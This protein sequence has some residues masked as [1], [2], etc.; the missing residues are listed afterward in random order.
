[1]WANVTMSHH[2]AQPKAQP[3]AS[4]RL[5]PPDLM[6]TVAKLA[7]SSGEGLSPTPVTPFNLTRLQDV[8]DVK[9]G[10]DTLLTKNAELGNLLQ[11]SLSRSYLFSIQSQRIGKQIRGLIWSLFYLKPF[12]SLGDAN[13]TYEVSL[14]MTLR[15][16]LQHCTDWMSQVDINA[17]TPCKPGGWFGTFSIFPYKRDNHPNWLSYF[18]EGLKPPTRRIC[19]VFHIW[20]ECDGLLRWNE[21]SVHLERSWKC[22]PWDIK[23]THFLYSIFTDLLYMNVFVSLI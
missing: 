22:F 10:D 13:Q 23:D 21:F 3:K 9:D 12:W 6:A 14:G 17:D 5:S 16:L 2:S 7:A 15:L 11:Y 1:M 8:K 19:V 20:F 18:S 4:L